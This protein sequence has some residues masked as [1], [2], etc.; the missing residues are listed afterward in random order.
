MPPNQEHQ[1]TA[2][3]ACSHP[4]DGVSCPLIRS[5]GCSGRSGPR[6]VTEG[7]H[8]HPSPAFGP[9]E[10]PRSPQSAFASHPDLTTLLGD[11]SDAISVVTVV[12][13]SLAGQELTGAGDEEVTLRHT[14]A[15]LRSVYDR[16]DRAISG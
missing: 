3:P 10:A 12:D 1:N 2:R 5:I 7:H 8:G 4:G 13:R 14:L 11:L 15:L 6:T 16:L 9:P